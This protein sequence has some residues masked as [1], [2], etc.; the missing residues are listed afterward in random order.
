[1]NEAA[2]VW[3]QILDSFPAALSA[4]L[5]ISAACSFLGVFVVLKRLVFIGATLS[6]VAACGVAVSFFFGFH[7]VAG[8]L[9]LTL[10]AVT[11]LAG[12]TSEEKI[13]KDSVL[14][15][16]FIAASSLSV[17]LAAKSAFGLEEIK[18]LLYGDLILTSGQDLG[19]LAVTVLPA[20][21]AAGVFLR[22]ILFTFLDRDEARILKI[23]VVV[24][25]LVFYYALAVVVSASSK[26]GGMLLVFCMLVVPPMTALLL[27]KR[28][29]PALFLSVMFAWISV[30]TGFY[31]SFVFDFPVNPVIGFASCCL[32][33]AA[34]AAKRLLRF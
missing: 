15:A 7:P 20:A 21:A 28:L 1:M 11:L 32:L 17:L 24:W 6:E 19:L 34:A 5:L 16:V 9:I 27:S 29:V 12:N 33:G 4:G 10:A 22:P 13:P 14:A 26:L 3:S 31:F 25:E 23:R 2:G 8:A 30:A 18:S